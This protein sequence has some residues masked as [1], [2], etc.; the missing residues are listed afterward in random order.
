M[1][2]L[3]K[4]IGVFLFGALLSFGVGPGVAKAQDDSDADR[5]S[6]HV[7]DHVHVSIE[8]VVYVITRNEIGHEPFAFSDA[9]HV[10]LFHFDFH[11]AVYHVPHT[12]GHVYSKGYRW[13]HGWRARSNC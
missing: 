4:L 11:K 8:P 13:D 3:F 6:I 12:I 9:E 7:N 1:K 10:P 5:L 2:N